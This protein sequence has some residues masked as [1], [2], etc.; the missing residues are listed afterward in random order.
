MIFVVPVEVNVVPVK[1][2]VVV[3]VV[4]GFLLLPRHFLLLLPRLQFR[5]DH[6]FAFC[7]CF[8]NEESHCLGRFFFPSQVQKVVQ[9]CSFGL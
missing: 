9:I 3:A 7:C 2:A 1:V 8:G 5:F 6:F 4:V